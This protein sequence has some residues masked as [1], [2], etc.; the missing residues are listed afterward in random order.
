MTRG[1]R[2][3]AMSP[4]GPKQVGP[5]LFKHWSTGDNQQQSR[6][7]P[8]HDKSRK[9]TRA[10]RKGV[11]NLRRE[12]I[13][14]NVKS[15]TRIRQG[16]TACNKLRER[17]VLK[18]V[19]TGGFEALDLQLSTIRL[20]THGHIINLLCFIFHSVLSF[21]ASLFQLHL[22]WANSQV[23][24]LNLSSGTQNTANRRSYGSRRESVRH[25]VICSQIVM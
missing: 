10:E 25:R 21:V 1:T 2:L 15:K 9:N 20:S 18:N 13:L 12:W 4:A 23:K 22:P 14:K 6:R 5:R 24:A 16:I 7:M 3:D 19:R 11:W 8:E 17:Y